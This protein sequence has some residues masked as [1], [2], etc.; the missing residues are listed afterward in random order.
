[1]NQIRADT[2]LS[3]GSRGGLQDAL[4]RSVVTQILYMELS[5]VTVI[6]M[7]CSQQVRRKSFSPSTP[8]WMLKQCF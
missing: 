7:I 4:E 8:L 3:A 2:F 1:M 6:Y 5:Y